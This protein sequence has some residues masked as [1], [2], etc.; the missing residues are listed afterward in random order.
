MKRACFLALCAFLAA[1]CGDR[2]DPVP[3]KTEDP[4]EAKRRRIGEIVKETAG[5]LAQGAPSREAEPKLK[6]LAAE[7]DALLRDLA[8]ADPAAQ[9]K[10]LESAARQYAPDAWKQ[11]QDA[12]LQAMQTSVKSRLKLLVTAATM[13]RAN[14]GDGNGQ[15]DFWVADVSGLHRMLYRG[16]P[17]KEI[18]AATAR[19]DARPCVPLDREGEYGGVK[20]AAVG[21]HAPFNGYLF[22]AVPKREVEKG[23][24]EPYAD[25]AGRNMAHFAFAAW[26]EKYG[27]TGTLTFLICEDGVLRWKDTGG[28]P[29]EVFPADLAAEGWKA[30]E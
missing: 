22:G 16:A 13:L 29:P 14:D 25:A 27:E 21:A 10:E 7:R 15:Q 9:Q 5:I 26:P 1:G 23:K 8:S 17:A 18:D 28:V 11:L 19:A 3:A 4:R 6:A 30:P 24:V 20:L 2:K 12:R